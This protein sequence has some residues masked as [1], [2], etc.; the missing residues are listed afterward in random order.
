[1]RIIVAETT[2]IILGLLCSAP[3]N[4]AA[5]GAGC[6]IQGPEDPSV[7]GDLEDAV[8]QLGD[9][10]TAPATSDCVAPDP[11]NCAEPA[12]PEVRQVPTGGQ[13]GPR[14]SEEKGDVT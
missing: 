1:M 4:A 11:S 3:L 2:L 7:D 8:P 12:S 14:F 6:S 5:P 9:L 13:T 10:K